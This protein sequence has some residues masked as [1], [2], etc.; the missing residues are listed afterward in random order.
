MHLTMVRWP[1]E[2][3]DTEIVSFMD[4]GIGFW[5]NPCLSL[6]WKDVFSCAASLP[7]QRKG[8][9][10]VSARNVIFVL[11]ASLSLSAQ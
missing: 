8:L 2:M 6:F 10:Q 4:R 1:W 7:S 9:D 3:K 5:I 11:A